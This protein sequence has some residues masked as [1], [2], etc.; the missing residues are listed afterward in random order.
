MSFAGLRKGPDEITLVASLSNGRTLKRT[1]RFQP[2]GPVAVPSHECVSSGSVT[3]HVS[4]LKLPRGARI[5][6]S[7]ILLHGQVVA[8]LGGR[9]TAAVVSF[10]GLREGSYEVTLVASLSNGHTLRQRMVF[11]AC[12]AAHG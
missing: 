3:V 4:E 6:H 10:A 1:I 9:A 5:E 7:E 8:R 2:C 12:A 11:H